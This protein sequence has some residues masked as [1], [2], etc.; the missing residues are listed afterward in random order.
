MS[1][2]TSVA[3]LVILGLASATAL[4]ACGTPQ[5]GIPPIARSGGKFVT[6]LP[7]GSA[8]VI[9][10]TVQVLS[11][12][13][14]NA[15][16][17]PGYRG[18]VFGSL[19]FRMS[20]L[21]QSTLFD[22]VLHSSQVQ[23]TELKVLR[24]RAELE[25]ALA[26]V[27]P[28]HDLSVPALDFKNEQGLLLALGPQRTGMISVRIQ[29]VLDAGDHLVVEAVRIFPRTHYPT[30]DIGWPVDLVVVN[31]LDMPVELAPVP[32]VHPAT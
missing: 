1:S 11:S 10:R 17:T 29:R 9:G 28:A 32:D 7:T 25:Q 5:E 16:A 21:G 20:A 26:Q 15:D 22:G 18:P 2:R 4:G 23:H 30:M 31:R 6:S 12:A 27:A 24:S 13:G 8:Q 14:N 3:T 19:P